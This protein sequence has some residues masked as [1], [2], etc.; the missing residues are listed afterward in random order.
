MK[1]WNDD[2]LRDVIPG[3]RSWRAVCRALGMTSYSAAPVLRQ[4]AERLGLDTSHFSGQRKWSARDLAPAVAASSTWGELSARLGFEHFSGSTQ[5][6][7][8]AH[9]VRLGV[10]LSHLNGRSTQIVS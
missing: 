8:K 10:D 1:Q 9:A 6:T 5:S 7:I 4:R 3:C 2:Q